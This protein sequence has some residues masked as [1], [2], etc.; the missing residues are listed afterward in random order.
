MR[1]IGPG[2]HTVITGGSSGLGLE[3]AHQLAP[4]G[5]PITLIA[6]DPARLAAAAEAILFR[7]P[8]AQVRFLSLDVS[9][10]VT[11]RAAFADLAAEVGGIDLLINCAGILI[12]GHTSQLTPQ[13]FRAVMNV[14]FFGTVNACGAALV[15]LAESRGT[16][17]N[18]SS[19][20]GLMGV[21]GYTAYCA[22]KHAIVGYTRALS[23]EAEPQGIRVVLACPGEFDSP[24][25]DA[26][27]TGRTPENRVHTLTIPKLRVAQVASEII[28][29]IQAGHRTIIPG[30]R[31]RAAVLANRL[32]PR[33]VE[34]VA[35][36][37]IAGVYTGP[38]RASETPS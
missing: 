33:I 37:R 23:Y 32:V 3:I 13:D 25:V 38:Q 34:A 5:G 27:D 15:P 29:G 35:R 17:V 9:E 18:I 31:T 26:L 11:V 28:A 10:P 30:R 20:A 22:S 19:A 8:R 2:T 12:E 14:N 7:T 36:R 24:M 16:L 6:R 4:G 21:F 1:P